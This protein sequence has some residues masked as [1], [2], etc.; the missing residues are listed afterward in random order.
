MQKHNQNNPSHC[1]YTLANKVFK[2]KKERKKERI[3]QK[4]NER[5]GKHRKTIE[6][7]RVD[8]E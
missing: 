6:E 7:Q 2:K 8:R 1:L 4:K 5:N 3:W